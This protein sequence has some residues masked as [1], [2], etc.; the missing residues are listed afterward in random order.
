M[1]RILFISPTSVLGGPTNS[2]LTI[3]GLI[4]ELHEVSVLVPRDGEF[5]I[6]LNQLGVPFHLA[7][8]YGLKKFAIPWL[9]QFLIKGEY[10]LVYGNGFNT[11]TRNVLIAAKF[12]RKPF[13]W[14]IREMV[15]ISNGSLHKSKFLQFADLF[16]A[17][18]YIAVRF[19][20]LGWRF[21]R[22]EELN[23][24]TSGNYVVNKKQDA[25]ALLFNEISKV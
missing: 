18:A 25:R 19:N 1:P 20:N 16:G 21:Y 14:H 12:T 24:T 7:G 3:L 4:K 9:I 10:D 23:K 17:E 15:K 5:L 11:G 6:E 13:I 8:K 2:L 22:P